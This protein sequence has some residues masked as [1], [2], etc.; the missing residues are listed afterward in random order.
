M[1]SIIELRSAVRFPLRLPV[2]VKMNHQD[3][4]AETRDISAAGVLLNCDESQ[5]VGSNI[6]FTILMPARA[7][8]A[9]KDVQVQCIGRV[10]RCSPADQGRC[11]IAAI[12][13]EYRFSR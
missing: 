4:L 12:I 7:V 8:G 5:E 6:E 3:H 2:A 1:A 10:V 9:S 11:S 13:D